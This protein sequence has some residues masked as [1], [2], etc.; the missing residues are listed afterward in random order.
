MDWPVG[1]SVV[2]DAAEKDIG[3]AAGGPCAGGAGPSDA[4][5]CSGPVADGEVKESMFDI[6][7]TAGLD[8]L[9]GGSLD[10]PAGGVEEDSTSFEVGG[11]D[12]VG[13]EELYAS[14]DEEVTTSADG[15]GGVDYT[16]INARSHTVINTPRCTY[17]RTRSIVSI[18]ICHS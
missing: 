13:G 14:G 2:D 4:C 8:E 11:L 18:G 6:L 17:G 9:E 16:M 10:D 7:V 1:P 15:I 12:E 5:P 3:G